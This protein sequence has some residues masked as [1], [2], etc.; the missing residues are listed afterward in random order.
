MSVEKFA[1]AG[2]LFDSALALPEENRTAYLKEACGEDELLLREVESLLAAHNQAKGF[3]QTPAFQ[4]VDL[5]PAE[6]QLAEGLQIGAYK[7]V[8]QI[9]R[10]GM[11]AVYLA[12]RADKQFKKYVAIKVVKRGMDTEYILRHF[13]NERQILASFDHAN[14]ARL[15]DGGSTDSGL[16]YFVMEYVEGNPVDQYCDEKQLNITQRLELFQQVCAA[17]AYAHRNL[18]VHRDIKPSNILVTSDGVPK[19]LDFGIAKIMQTDEAGLTATGI[20]VMTPEFASPEQAQGQPVTTLSDVYSLGVVLYELLTGHSPYE[21]KSRT[22]I[23]IARIITETQPVLPSS[24]IHSEYVNTCEGTVDRLRRRLRGDLDNIV[25][26][27]LRKEP[28]RRYQSVE[29]FS[30]DISRHLTGMPVQARKD[31]FGYRVGKFVQR[32]KISAAVALVAFV[33]IAI[34]AGFAGFI[35]WKANQEAKFLQE[36]G[37][38]VARIE[39]IMRIAHLLP[40]HNIQP[41]KKQVIQSLE[42]LKREMQTLGTVAYGPGHYSLG[43]GYLALQRHQ[44]AYE[45]LFKAWNDYEYRIPAVEYW[46]GYSLAMLYQEKLKETAQTTGKSQLSYKK[47]QLKKT[48]RDPALE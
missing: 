20:H 48:Y 44:T 5:T 42:R 24:I 10:G 26:M 4:D 2:E 11:G 21:I 7:I 35:K 31:T 39:G 8:R 33:A 25:L 34:F 19:L 46:L 23:E 30:A 29:Q 43:R 14:I 15:L 38:E 36:F 3:M 41:E 47:E 1:K 9:G 32:N 17:V 6:D 18:V 45:H 12:E 27:A 22:S 28:Q 37:Q 16:P 40:L 13:R